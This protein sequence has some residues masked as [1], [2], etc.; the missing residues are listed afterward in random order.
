MAQ[1]YKASSLPDILLLD[2]SVPGIFHMATKLKD[3]QTLVVGL[4]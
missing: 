1:T 4:L 3:D 2:L